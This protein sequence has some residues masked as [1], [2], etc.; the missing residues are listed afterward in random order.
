MERYYSVREVMTMFGLSQSTVYN[1]CKSKVLPYTKIG[2]SIRFKESDLIQ[3]MDEN[4]Q[5][6]R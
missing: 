2:G 1:L 5:G 3:Y 4:K 6:G